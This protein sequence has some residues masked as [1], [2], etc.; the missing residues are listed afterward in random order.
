MSHHK[1]LPCAGWGVRRGKPQSGGLPGPAPPSAGLCR[2]TAASTGAPRKWAHL[3]KVRPRQEG[4]G[5]E[6]LWLHASVPW[7]G[8]G[9]TVVSPAPAQWCGLEPRSEPLEDSVSSS[10]VWERT[11]SPGLWGS[12][13]SLTG[14]CRGPGWGGCLPLLTGAFWTELQKEK[15]ALAHPE[16]RLWSQQNQALEPGVSPPRE[17]LP[18][19]QQREEATQNLGSPLPFGRAHPSSHPAFPKLFPRQPQKLLIHREISSGV[20]VRE[21]F[22]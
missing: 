14:G 6:A 12:W 10:V 1:V 22:K 8:P 7:S 17:Q 15:R 21:A 20:P 9:A 18:H 3:A 16:R 13:A 4:A 11:R 19:R 2:S 5:R